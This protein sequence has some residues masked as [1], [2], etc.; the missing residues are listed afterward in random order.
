M[1][2]IISVILV[3]FMLAA[4][5]APC[6]WAADAEEEDFCTSWGD[7]DGDKTTTSGDARLVLRQ[8]VGLEN[9][10]EA[11]LYRADLDKD[12]SVSSS[13]ARSVLRL[14]VG[15]E[16]Y[17]PH[18]KLP[19]VGKD[20]TCT[21]DGMTDGVYCAIC[22]QELVPQEVI[23]H[24]GHKAIVDAAIPATC[25]EAGKTE[26]SHCEVCGEILKAQEE[27]PALG[28]HPV[29]ITATATDVCQEAQKCDRCGTELLPELK[30]D[31][32]ANATVTAEK[33]IS[34]KRCGKT[35]VPS[36]N[37]LV[38]PLKKEEHTFRAFTKTDSHI[39]SP[40]FTGIM[41]LPSIKNSFEEEFKNNMGGATEYNS[42]TAT[43]TVSADNFEVLYSDYV[44][45]LTD[46]D[47]QSSKTEYVKGV[48]FLSTL[49]DTFTGQYGKTNDLTDIK[50]KQ[51]GDVIKVTVTLK[52]EQY[53]KTDRNATAIPKI[54][55]Y[56]NSVLVDA[57]NEFS[58]L[59]ADF[60]KS[61]CDSLSTVN[62]VYYF[63]KV[64]LAPIAA[65]YSIK[66]D[67]DQSMSI[68]ISG[69]TSDENPIPLSLGTAGSISFEVENNIYTYCFF[70]AN[71]D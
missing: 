61:E 11:A 29:T 13:D 40:K 20:V 23:P 24:P 69:M 37:E 67:M 7:M 52:P 65:V 63:D 53:S 18:E 30:H 51:F 25:T 12:G 22:E 55:T 9:Y 31:I 70:D 21:V 45:L 50:S 43:E 26:G 68:D 38:N 62:V 1:K 56:Y 8:S 3:C 5:S 32:A 71:F 58:S 59:N 42:L 17:P 33:G 10:D 44:S 60:M 46:Q 2:K 34:C 64:T 36:F 47:L 66:M 39:N 35:T 19:I 27:A 54:S 15:L 4:L 57:I 6:V 48:D 14:S 41:A 16:A 28:H 49:P